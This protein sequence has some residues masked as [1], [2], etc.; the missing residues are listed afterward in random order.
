MIGEVTFVI[1]GGIIGFASSYF[2][3]RVQTRYKQ[4]NVARALLTELSSLEEGLK[5]FAQVFVNPPPQFNRDAP[6]KINQPF[7]TE[8]LFFSF[9]KEISSFNKELSNSLFQFYMHLLT[10]EQFRQVGETDMFFKQLNN[11][12]KDNIVKAYRLL[13][14]LKKLL[15]KEC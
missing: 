3:W 4:K 10:A 11:A 7:Y 2:M 6:V 12:M 13:P 8:G 1:I 5:T 15:E 9:R 14:D